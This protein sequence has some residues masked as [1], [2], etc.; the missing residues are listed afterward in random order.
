MSR[1]G[2]YTCFLVALSTLVHKQLQTYFCIIKY[3]KVK[4]QKII[5]ADNNKYFRAGLKRILSN[6]GNVEIVAEVSNG[7]GLLNVLEQ[8]PVDIV[9]TEVE[10]PVEVSIDLI[11]I[12]HLRYPE[13]KF[14]AFSSLENKRYVDKFL[15]VGASGYLFKSSNN[16]DIF[17]KILINSGNRIFLS[18]ELI[19]TNNR[20]EN[21][22]VN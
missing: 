3:N 9:F 16:Y 19:K 2:I 15:E 22:L 1:M 14:I 21:T 10:K 17:Q 7:L 5:I 13:T 4:I 11:R 8:K 6:I 12:G 20:F 18:T